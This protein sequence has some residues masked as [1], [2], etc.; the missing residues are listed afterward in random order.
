MIFFEQVG[1][2]YRSKQIV[3][4]YVSDTRGAY[5]TSYSSPKRATRFNFREFQ[6]E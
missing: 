3:T 1:V 5:V 2:S 4:S 6:L